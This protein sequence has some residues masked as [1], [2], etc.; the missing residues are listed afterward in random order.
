MFTSRIESPIKAAYSPTGKTTVNSS[1]SELAESSLSHSPSR[2]S[3][4]VTFAQSECPSPKD[5]LLR[6]ADVS[7]GRNASPLPLYRS[8]SSLETSFLPNS[9]PLRTN[10]FRNTTNKTGLRR[11]E[12]NSSKNT[13]NP[14]DIFKT[15]K[16]LSIEIKPKTENESF[17]NEP[18]SVKPI[19]INATNNERSVVGPL[20]SNYSFAASHRPRQ[21]SPASSPLIS[22]HNK[23]NYSHSRSSENELKNSDQKPTLVQPNLEA[24]LPRLRR[25]ENGRYLSETSS[26][27][28][29]TAL[30]LTKQF[31]ALNARFSSPSS[32]ARSRKPTVRTNSI[33]GNVG[34]TIIVTEPSKKHHKDEGTDDIR[35]VFTEQQLKYKEALDR[36]TGDRKNSQLSHAITDCSPIM[37]GNHSKNTGNSD[38]DIPQSRDDKYLLKDNKCNGITSPT[39][40]AGQFNIQNRTMSNRSGADGEKVDS[41]SI[42]TGA[43]VIRLRSRNTHSASVQKKYDSAMELNTLV[44]DTVFASSPSI[45]NSPSEIASDSIVC[46]EDKKKEDMPPWKLKQR[47]RQQERLQTYG[48]AR[49]GSVV[50]TQR[51]PA[52]LKRRQSLHEQGAALQQQFTRWHQQLLD[53]PEPT[54]NLKKSESWNAGFTLSS[55]RIFTPPEKMSEQLRTCDEESARVNSVG[56]R[57]LFDAK[58]SSSP[59]ARDRLTQLFVNKMTE[60]LADGRRLRVDQQVSDHKVSNISP[61]LLGINKSQNVTAHGNAQ[62]SFEG[63]NQLKENNDAASAEQI[64]F[65]DEM[66]KRE[67][68]SSLGTDRESRLGESSVNQTY[69]SMSYES[70]NNNLGSQRY[71]SEEALSY[72]ISRQR[73]LDSSPVS[74]NNKNSVTLKSILKKSVNMNSSS[75]NLNAI[76]TLSTY[77]HTFEPQAPTPSSTPIVTSTSGRRYTKATPVVATPSSAHFQY[78]K[79]N[80]AMTTERGR[81]DTLEKIDELSPPTSPRYSPGSMNS[82][83]S[84]FAA[85]QTFQQRKAAATAVQLKKHLLT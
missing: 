48:K 76:H 69:R 14:G 21:E 33:A 51:K 42:K 64:A 78:S 22:G 37:N 20:A 28:V 71:H 85:V 44:D 66:V 72:G 24:L 81:R 49:P 13:A 5:H 80:S 77:A 10:S 57:G 1:D 4:K 67:V 61:A 3:E 84:K 45:Y 60:S 31:E 79:A 41:E 6:S 27:D 38:K 11:S 53:S 29:E 50:E 39:A 15:Q 36:I 19:L 26:K 8:N 25:A 83:P 59:P 2:S 34:E 47:Q 12:S 73:S 54:S 23:Y 55:E 56:E 65:K 58:S 75:E 9:A 82:L 7:G 18:L 17:Y 43:V 30:L 52:T 74:I 35:I 32:D 63:F 70:H 62:S 40:L 16:R 68:N 46:S